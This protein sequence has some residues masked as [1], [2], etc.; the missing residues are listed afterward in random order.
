MIGTTVSHYKIVE[1]LGQG[2]MGVVYRAEDLKLRRSVALKFLSSGV[3]S[4]K[5]EETRFTYEARAAAALNHP[6]ICTVY[7]IGDYEGRP[8]IAMEH[9]GGKSLKDQVSSGGPLELEG[10][11]HIE[12]LEVSSEASRLEAYAIESGNITTWVWSLEDGDAHVLRSFECGP[13]HGFVSN[14]V[15]MSWDSTRGLFAKSGP[16][17]FV[18]LWSLAAPADAQPLIL[19]RGEVAM[20]LGHAFHPDRQWLATAQIPGLTLWPL[21]RGYPWVIAAHSDTVNAVAFGPSGEWLASGSEGGTVRLTPLAGEV[22]EATSLEHETSYVRSVASSPDGTLL[23]LGRMYRGAAL[24]PVHGGPAADLGHMAHAYGVSFSPDGRFAAA[25]GWGADSTTKLHVFRTDTL[26]ETAVLE[27]HETGAIVMLDERRSFMAD[28]RVL[29]VGPSGL[30]AS[31]PKTGTSERLFEGICGDFAAGA[32]GR[33]IVVVDRA[34]EENRSPSRVVLLDLL[35]S[36]ETHLASYGNRVFSI[37]MNASGTTIVTGGH[38]GVVRVGSTDGSEPHLLLGHEGWVVD[39]DIDPNERWVASG[40]SDT[41]VRIWPMP[42][43]SKPP[44]HTLPHDDLLAKL[45]TLTN[46]RVVRDEEDPTGWTLTHDPF[47]GWETVPR[48]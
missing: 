25:T 29:S 27:P 6:N 8:F 5:E 45:K 28:G 10:P 37:A 46:L 12:Y 14:A 11:P 41:T 20:N 7:E 21:S 2:G 26:E 42:D 13:K 36:T 44:L 33:N 48:W 17:K 30:W 43:L 32:D 22:P 15:A 9:V 19:R 35:A 1:K 23:L 39:V 31:D 34:T 3:V 16:G 47:P 38:D 18:R 4:T 40:G 24:L